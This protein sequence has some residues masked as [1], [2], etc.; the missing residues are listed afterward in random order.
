MKSACIERRGK[1]P[2]QND[3][4]INGRYCDRKPIPIR[5]HQVFGGGDDAWSLHPSSPATAR[6]RY[7]VTRRIYSYALDMIRKA[8][9]CITLRYVIILSR[10]FA[11]LRPHLWAPKCRSDSPPNPWRMIVIGE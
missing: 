7:P 2:K 6:R 1:R 8:A 4:R 10:W 3:E 11:K 5:L 9:L